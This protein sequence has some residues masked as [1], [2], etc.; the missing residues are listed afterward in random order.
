[1]LQRE[2]VITQ[3]VLGSVV[4]ASPS[5]PKQRDILLAAVREA[6]QNKYTLLQTFASVLCNFT[7]NV[8]LG[9]DIQRDYG[10]WILY[11]QLCDYH[12]FKGKYFNND[13]ENLVK[14]TISDDTSTDTASTRTI[15]PSPSPLSSPTTAQT[16]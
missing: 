4:S 1:M 7:G 16:G 9:A 14:V 6:V 15:T 12:L 11:L 8:Q 10:K 13:N 3:D 2:S 5:V